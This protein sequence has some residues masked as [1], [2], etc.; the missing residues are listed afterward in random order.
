MSCKI[1]SKRER[2]NFLVQWVKNLV[3]SLQWLWLLL[4][5]RF[6][7]CPQ[8]TPHGMGTAKKKQKKKVVVRMSPV[9]RD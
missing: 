2:E 9:F 4:W 6:D 3:L 5:Q 1:S 7:P 8:E